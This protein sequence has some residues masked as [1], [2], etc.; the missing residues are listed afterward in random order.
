[1]MSLLHFRPLLLLIPIF[2][3]GCGKKNAYVEPPPP[4][5]SVEQ[6]HQQSVTEYLEFSGVAKPIETVEVRARVQG[7]LKEILFTEG[8]EVKQGELLLVI[9]EETFQIQLDAA[10]V[11]LKSAQVALRQ[12]RESKAREIASAQVAL[13]ESQLLLA[14]QEEQRNRS[15]FARNAFPESDL[16]KTIATRKTAEAKVE[17][18][19]AMLEQATAT[20]GTEIME[21]EAKVT[22]AEIDVR[23]A[24]LDLSY[25]RMHSPIDGRISRV[26]FDKG[27]LVGGGQASVLATIVR[28]DPIYAYTNVSED[29]F[30]RARSLSKQGLSPNGEG[31]TIHAELAFGGQSEFAYAGEINYT[32]PVVDPGT[33]TLQARGIFA[34]TDRAILPGMFVRVRVPIGERPDSLLVPVRALGTDQTGEY[35]LVVGGDGKVEHRTVKAGVEINGLRVVEG[36]LA[37]GDQVIVDGLLRARP[38]LKVTPKASASAEVPTTAAGPRAYAAGRL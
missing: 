15:L 32:D 2:A 20:Y 1:M 8:A 35:V 36:Q 11:K 3:L 13:D 38:G 34:N 27:N 18:S 12:A 25:C 17:S 22:A 29:E 9:D 33:G 19:R 4:E 14:R 7:F 10:E 16:E 23:N 6:P 21:A 24:K 37:A 26:N 5:V 31:T 28:L 30:L